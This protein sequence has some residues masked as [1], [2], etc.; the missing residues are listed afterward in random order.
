MREGSPG[1]ATFD[2]AATREARGGGKKSDELERIERRRASIPLRVFRGILARSPCHRRDQPLR[3]PGGKLSR[4][5]KAGVG[6][7]ATARRSENDRANRFPRVDFS[8][9]P[10]P[11]S[12]FSSTRGVLYH[13]SMV[14]PASKTTAR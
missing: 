7:W 5:E 13:A 9:D 12:S 10:S 3:F 11:S 8:I 6:S 1:G 14:I 2:F 4:R